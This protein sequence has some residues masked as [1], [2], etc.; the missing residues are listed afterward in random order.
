M[1]QAW[2]LTAMGT[3]CGLFGKTRQAYYEACWREEKVI[4][5]Q[6]L[7]L[8]EVKR[9]RKDLPRVGTDKLYFLLAD[10][11]NKNQIKIGRDKLYTLLRAHHLLIKRTKRRAITTN[12]NHPFY[13]Y[14]NLVQDFIPLKPNELWVSDITYVLLPHKFAYLS[15]ITDAYSKKI[16]GWSLQENLQSKGP[17]EA[18]KMALHHSRRNLDNL[19][20]HSDRGT[21]YCSHEYIKLLKKHEISIS[22]TR[23]GDPGE[24][25]I[26]ER[27][28]GTIKNEFYCRGFISFP[29]AKESIAKAIHAY[30]YLRPHASCDYLTPA[31]AHGKAGIL[32]KRWSRNYSKDYNLLN[33]I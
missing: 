11:F 29:L 31:Q 30:N 10:F 17:L 3:V 8:Q 25:A 28:N 15:L 33:A 24:N 5:E 18:L 14:P 13:K 16:I 12:S 6:E 23:D 7:I 19:I 2:P 9:I 1:N 26:A 27:I 32:N 22:M 21:Q 20:H 4:N